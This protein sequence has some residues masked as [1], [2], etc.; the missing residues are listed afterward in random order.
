[1]GINFIDTANV[2][3]K[4][5]EQIQDAIPAADIVVPPEHLIR[6]DA[7]C[8]PPWRQPDPIRGS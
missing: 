6:L 2:G 4:S 7:I 3:V 5:L 8:P 1:M